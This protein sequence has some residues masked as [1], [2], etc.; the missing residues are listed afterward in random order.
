MALR[1]VV[2]SGLAPREAGE[3]A[4]AEVAAEAARA[5]GRRLWAAAEAGRYE[6]AREIARAMPAPGF[7]ADETVRR[8]MRTRPEVVGPLLR[9]LDPRAYDEALAEVWETASRYVDDPRTAAFLARPEVAGLWRVGSEG[10]AAVMGAR[11]RMFLRAGDPA[12]VLGV[13]R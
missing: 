4:A 8:L 6:E 12:R 10:A 1:R 13:W 3:Q 5:P 2:V 9:G 11:A 7:A